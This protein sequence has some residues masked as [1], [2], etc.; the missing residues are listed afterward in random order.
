[1]MGD[2][3]CRNCISGVCCSVESCQYHSLNNACTAPH[4]DVKDEKAGTKKETFCGTYR[5]LDSGCCM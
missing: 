1:M 4:I 2:C 5:P 3:E